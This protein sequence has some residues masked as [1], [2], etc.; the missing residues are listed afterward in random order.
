MQ[1][2]EFT[3][4][5][6]FFLGWVTIAG[7]D[8][9]R[10][11]MFTDPQMILNLHAGNKVQLYFPEKNLALQ[12]WVD[13]QTKLLFSTEI[14]L[15]LCNQVLDANVDD[16]QTY[17]AVSRPMAMQ[18]AVSCSKYVAPHPFVDR[19]KVSGPIKMTKSAAFEKR[20]Y[21]FIISENNQWPF[22]S[23]TDAATN[24]TVII[25]QGDQ[26][27]SHLFSESMA[28]EFAIYFDGQ[29][30][31]GTQEWW[32]IHK[33]EKFEITNADQEKLFFAVNNPVIAAILSYMR[34]FRVEQQILQE[35]SDGYSSEFVKANY[36][37][38]A[39]I[40]LNEKCD[41]NCLMNFVKSQS[42]AL[43]P[44]ALALMAYSGSYKDKKIEELLQK[45]PSDGHLLRFTMY[46]FGK[47]LAL[48]PQYHFL[49]FIA[50]VESMQNWIPKRLIPA[51]QSLFNNSI[52]PEDLKLLDKAR[53]KL[54]DSGETVS[55]LQWILK[56][57][58]SGRNVDFSSG[59]RPRI[60]TGGGGYGN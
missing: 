49:P 12:N 32:D 39:F 38:P 31:V 25:A 16:L 3:K 18:I 8:V 37:N 13:R 58:L 14:G 10:P 15:A 43:T 1:W 54:H 7:A 50:L 11:E 41:H 27:D 26:K 21:Q 24:Q 56:P 44:Y 23:W 34:A 6:F 22:D 36:D 53:V 2:G 29:Y 42:F 51:I 5:L 4:I 48:H 45:N 9:S 55:F 35:I 46:N 33:D 30:S 57:V 52:L 59:P 40:F 47:Q 60:R 20:H 17:L 28:H 19:Y